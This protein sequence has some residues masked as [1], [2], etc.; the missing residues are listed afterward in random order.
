[1]NC[2]FY[3][4]RGRGIIPEITRSALPKGLLDAEKTN[5]AAHPEN[6]DHAEKK[7]LVGARASRSRLYYSDL[8]LLI[9]LL[10]K[11]IRRDKWIEDE[12]GGKSLRRPIC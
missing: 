9:T 5:A 4:I 12:K 1:M 3:D 7:A 10:L 2:S 11:D 6:L 8:L